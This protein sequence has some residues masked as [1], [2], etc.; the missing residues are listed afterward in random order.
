MED[1]YNEIDATE[2]V[3]SGEA[4]FTL[5]DADYET[6][7]LDYGNFTS[8]DNAKADLPAF[9]T[10]KFPVWGAESLA[11]VTFN[12]YSPIKFESY[13]VNDAD[14]AA[15]GLTSLNNSGDFND[16]FWIQVSK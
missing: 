16:F 8:I 14:Y 5:T 13:V 4:V 15:I 2:T 6:L 12:L 1:I 10:N 11:E 3:I 7:E 9:L